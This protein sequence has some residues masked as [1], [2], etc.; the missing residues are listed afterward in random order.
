MHIWGA[1]DDCLDTSDHDSLGATFDDAHIGIG[2]GLPPGVQRP[3]AL[4]VGHRHAEGQVGLLHQV[5]I[6]KE[7]LMMIGAV[8]GVCAKRGLMQGRERVVSQIPLGAAGFLA[9]QPH[10]FQLGQQVMCAGVDVDHPV[11]H[12]AIAVA[13]G[14]HSLMRLDQRQIVGHPDRRDPRFECRCVG[15]RVDRHTV[16]EHFGRIRPQGVPILLGGQQHTHS[17]SCSLF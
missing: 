8:R 4:G 7:P 10:R 16:N 2:V 17:N 1:G 14:H 13:R 9:D 3:I 11:H 6:R 5:Q 12:R 15:Y